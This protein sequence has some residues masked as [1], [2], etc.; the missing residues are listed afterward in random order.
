MFT[1]SNFKA[2]GRISP[3][4]IRHALRELAATSAWDDHTFRQDF[5]GS[6]HKDTK[7]IILRGPEVIDLSALNNL[8][9]VDYPYSLPDTQFVVSCA[10][11][12]LPVR[13]VGRIFVVSLR[14]G[15]HITRHA[16][17]GAYARHFSRM[18]VSLQSEQ[19]NDF[20]C[21]GETIH[22]QPGTVW[23]FNHHAE[24]EVWNRSQRERIHIIIDYKE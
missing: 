11:A 24:H 12:L 14:A 8:S 20:E 3:F 7:A 15:G 22:M 9:A 4:S 18:H 19:G 10:R 21:G 17:E 23:S 5:P 2:I 1:K 16:D 6:A 13:E